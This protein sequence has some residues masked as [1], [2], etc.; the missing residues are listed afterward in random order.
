LT[1]AKLYNRIFL[2]LY[3]GDP[4]LSQTTE[5]ALRAAVFLA[6]ERR[7]CTAAEIAEAASVPAGY[8]AKV[9]QQL[10]RAGVVSSQRGLGG[11]FALRGDP[12]D[13]SLLDVVQAVDPIRR[14]RSCPLDLPEHR[15]SLCALHRKLDDAYAV[16]EASFGDT[17]LAELTLRRARFGDPPVWPSAEPAPRRRRKK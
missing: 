2:S 15:R 6:I 1:R 7:P 16:I 4:V 5:Y 12:G 13:V 14:I 10:A 9:L 11:G 17:T 3:Q 8:L